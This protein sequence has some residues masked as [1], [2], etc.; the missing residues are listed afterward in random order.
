MNKPTDDLGLQFIKCKF[1]N[2]DLS[3][4]GQ[5]QWEILNI[6]CPQC[7]KFFTYAFIDGKYRPM[8]TFA[9]KDNVPPIS[10]SM[11]NAII[12]A[13]PPDG[14]ILELG[15]G[16]TTRLFAEKR[17]II[18][19]EHNEQYVRYYNKRENYI[20]APLVNDWYSLD[21]LLKEIPKEYD[22]LLVDGP[23]TDT[24][25]KFFFKYMNIFNPSIP[26]FLDDLDYK[27]FK[28]DF[29]EMIDICYNL[30]KSYQRFNDSKKAWGILI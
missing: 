16:S 1:C 14:T 11:F 10:E 5:T 20:H 29:S 12:E 8:P 6:T 3:V 30:G 28:D 9:W 15:S 7:K 4:P 27:P 2:S 22:I 26:W 13:C 25:I 21:I 17:N 24:R 19:I 18:S 23:D